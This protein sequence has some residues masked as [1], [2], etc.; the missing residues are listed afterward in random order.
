MEALEDNLVSAFKYWLAWGRYSSLWWSE[1]CQTTKTKSE[2]VENR[3]PG[4]HELFSAMI[5]HSLTMKVASLTYQQ[6]HTNRSFNPWL[7]IITKRIMTMARSLSITKIPKMI[8]SDPTKPYGILFTRQFGCAFHQTSQLPSSAIIK[9]KSS[10]SQI[11]M[12]KM[13]CT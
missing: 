7:D 8:D 2:T 4:K 1:W 13:Y 5:L 6:I 12:W 3:L 11:L 9:A 10:S